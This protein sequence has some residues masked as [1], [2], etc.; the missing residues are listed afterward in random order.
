MSASTGVELG[1]AERQLLVAVRA[2]SEWMSGCAQ[3]QTRPRDCMAA[4]FKV[5]L[6]TECG[7][8]DTEG[9]GCACLNIHGSM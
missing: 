3:T 2:N 9:R 7:S 8:C 1:A 4:C 5:A 6:S